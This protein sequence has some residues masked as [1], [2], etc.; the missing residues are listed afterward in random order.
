MEFNY[1]YG[2]INSR[3]FGLS[4]GISP[5]VDNTCNFGCVYCQL[6][7]TRYSDHKREE[8]V[9]LQ[10]IID[11]F[12]TVLECGEHFD[13]V[14]IVGDGEPLLHKDIIS[15]IRALKSRTS[16]PVALITNGAMLHEKTV[17]TDIYEA[18]IVS[19]SLDAFDET[20]FKRINRPYGGLSFE[21]YYDGIRTFSKAYSGELWLEIMFVKDMNDTD[22]AL[23][24]LKEKL[25]GIHYDRLYLNTPVRPP[26]E[27]D[28]R[29]P[30]TERMKHI[31]K[32]LG[33]IP[34][35]YLSAPCYQSYA[36][37]DMQAIKGLIRRHPM[38]QFEIEGFLKDRGREDIDAFM[39][40]LAKENDVEIIRK[41]RYRMHR[42]KH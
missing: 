34:I 7:K 11:E 33:G 40:R 8:H 18:D 26:T 25:Q 23:E 9:P 41:G 36:E 32:T 17:R 42:L 14:S 3:R 30:D 12:E 35:D 4:L 27:T 1:I 21:A 6:G 20:S 2:P 31:Q 13:V 19:P 24:K 5:V 16:R 39:Q 10:A 29:A 38:H 28:V 37:D 22:E 15:L